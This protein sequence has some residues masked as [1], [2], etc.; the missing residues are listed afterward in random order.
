MGDLSPD[1]GEGMEA[2][3]CQRKRSEG[4]ILVSVRYGDTEGFNVAGMESASVCRRKARY[5]LSVEEQILHC[6]QRRSD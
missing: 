2:G 6:V 1:S 5:A 3:K 4:G